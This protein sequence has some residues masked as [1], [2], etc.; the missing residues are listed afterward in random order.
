MHS[1]QSPAQEQ[2][3]LEL[4]ALIIE[5]IILPV[6]VIIQHDQQQGRQHDQQ[7]GRLQLHVI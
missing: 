2:T 4:V 3:A 1:E 5:I 6:L 7:Q